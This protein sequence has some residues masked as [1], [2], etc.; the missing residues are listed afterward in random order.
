[1]RTILAAALATSLS[2]MAAPAVWALGDD[3]HHDHHDEHG[4]EQHA[5]HEHGVAEMQLIQ[6]GSQVMIEVRSPAANITG[7]EHKASSHDEIAAVEAASQ[8]LDNAALFQVAGDNCQLTYATNT[9]KT[10]LL[11]EEED[12]H[13]HHDH[14]DEHHHD[15][16]AEHELEE[17]HADVVATYVYGCDSAATIAT[18][19]TTLPTIFPAME[20]LH[21]EWL[22]GGQQGFKE[23]SKSNNQID[24]GQ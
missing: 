15:D 7:F 24:F 10:A 20:E 3:H 6:D 16:H 11:D 23:L 5:A 19:S 14:H 4:H 18:I 9:L 13:H 21:V 1:M 12:D 2:V 8:Q 22:V 17:G